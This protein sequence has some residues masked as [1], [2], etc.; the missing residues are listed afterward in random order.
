MP[1]QKIGY[2]PNALDFSKADP[3]RRR[4][5]IDEDVASLCQLG[6]YVEMVDLREFFCRQSELQAK[7]DE[8]AAVFVSGGN[9]FVLRQVM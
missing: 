1:H 2:I 5:N 9:T 3:E 4:K 7:L 6:L 8:L